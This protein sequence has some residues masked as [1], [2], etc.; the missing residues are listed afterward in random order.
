M[1][2]AALSEFV[3]LY[4]LYALLFLDTGLSTAEISGL[5]AVW[6]VAAVLA[7][8]PAGA[9]ADRWSRRGV[10]VCGA[11]L[12]AAAFGLWAVAP[13]T[14]GFAA[15]FALW[16]VSSAL[17]SGTAEA[18][19]YDG[20]VDVGAEEAFPCVN[21][22][23]TAVELLAQ[24]PTALA[25]AA[26]HALGGFGL[27]AWASAGISLAAGALALRFPEPPRERAG[28]LLATLRA[29]A[30]QV[31]RHA[32]LRIA[33]GAVALVGG[34]DA[35]EEYFP[36]LAA[37]RGVPTGAVPFA[38]LAIALAGAA[39]AAAGGRADEV[40]DGVL[41]ALLASAALLL[42]VSAVLPAPGTVAALAL[43]YGLYLA[44]LVAA[45]ARLQERIEGPHRATVTSVAGLGVELAGVL[46]FAAWALG[47]AAATAVLVL[48]VVPVVTAGLRARPG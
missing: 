45:E 15:G 38:V 31:A 4:P 48:A 8:V 7:E 12:Q 13:G 33:V 36:V 19:V 41:P 16:G 35:M 25:A 26:L 14:A 24:V 28:A 21:G 22:R 17:Y 20:L 40:P 5:F 47:G 6:S 23:M 10:L 44:V 3:P 32:P 34:L 27:V 29:A 11:V 1:S 9:L 43:A 2:W 37:D 46:V 18:L 42:A 30:G 39:G